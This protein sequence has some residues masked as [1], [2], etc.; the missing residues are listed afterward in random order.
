MASLSPFPIFRFFN[1]AGAPLSGGKLYTYEAGTTT[2]LATYTNAGAGTPNANPIILD[3]N[4]ECAV[5]YLQ[6]LP[7][8]FNLTD[9]T[10]L[11]QPGW[12]Q[13]N[14]SNASVIALNNFITLLAGNTGSDQIGY[15]SAGS[16]SELISL[17]DLLDSEEVSIFK[18]MTE[19][20]RNDVQSYTGSVDVT[21][22]IQRAHDYA[23]GRVITGWGACRITNQIN[24]TSSMIGIG[25]GIFEGG[26]LS[27][28]W[29]GSSNRVFN[30]STYK[31]GWRFENFRVD[32]RNVLTPNTALYF[33][34]GL[35]GAKFSMIETRGYHSGP[36]WGGTYAD[37]DGILIDTDG[38]TNN[39]TQN[40]FDQVYLVKNRRGLTFLDG[41]L[42]GDGGG[43]IFSNGYGWCKEYNIKSTGPA[44]MIQGG[45]F[46]CEAGGFNFVQSGNF[47]AGWVY[48]GVQAT[49]AMNAD[50]IIR[51]DVAA[52]FGLFNWTGGN[53]SSNEGGSAKILSSAGNGSHIFRYTIS[54]ETNGTSSAVQSDNFYAGQGFYS[55]NRGTAD[56][57]WTTP[58]FSAG[59]YTGQG[60]MTVSVIAGNVGDFKY[61]F[62]GKTMTVKFSIAGITIG[63]T[64]SQAIR[65]AIPNSQT[66]ESYSSNPI[67]TK[68]NG[69]WEIGTAEVQAG[70]PYIFIYKDAA[71][72]NWS[73]SAANTS[74]K[75]ELSFEVS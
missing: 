10:G 60:A 6:D 17:Q 68:D 41:G 13:D 8:K 50:F 51:A 66:V 63:G 4:G 5:P 24:A 42:I 58:S 33:A 3:A 47:A 52:S 28:I 67:S 19:V 23:N 29:H 55:E 73:A 48:E 38:V 31:Q 45:D 21:S 16:G 75:G 72:G 37:H 27:F 74:F 14:I 56:G 69:T 49:Q 30:F 40:Q 2:P 25:G 54:G 46:N 61:T 36:A 44:F 35:V 53:I 12:P 32:T 43:N 62:Y 70:Q 59:D 34:G 7:Y 9:S 64:P 57:A 1:A 18:F 65:I 11:Q 15:K 20:Q 26:G 71:G 39:S 22:A